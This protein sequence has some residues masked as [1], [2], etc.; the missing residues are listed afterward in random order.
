[1]L[2]WKEFSSAAPVIAEAGSR[3]LGLNEVAF[4]ATVSATAR[5]RIHP[6]VPRIVEERIV[7]FIMDSSPKLKDLQNRRQYSIH[8]L[9]GNEDEE[10]FA[11][12]EA[13]YCDT[14]TR[15]RDAAANA[16]GFATGVDEHHILYEFRFDR[17]LHTQWL[18]F[19]TPKHRPKR[20]HWS[21]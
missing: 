8:T 1:M 4:L 12:G 17:A 19:G 5:P 3:L 16:M 11:S 7:A 15:F 2:G 13:V 21:L 20:T 18:D 14:E 10:F 6:V 9:P